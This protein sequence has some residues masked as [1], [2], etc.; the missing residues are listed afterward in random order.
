MIR[1][2]YVDILLDNQLL[3]TLEAGEI[4]GEMA[5]I[6]GNTR[7]ATA[8][9]S[10]DCELIAVTPQEFNYLIDNNRRFTLTL[11]RVLSD[12]IQVNNS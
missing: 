4:F 11:M 5:L 10:T 9:A 1:A 8:V 2:G 3:C 6:N 12:R 7:C